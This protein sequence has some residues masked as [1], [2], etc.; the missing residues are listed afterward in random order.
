MH[1][2]VGSSGFGETEAQ[3]NVG[4][5]S[6]TKLIRDH[7]LLHDPIMEVHF[8]HMDNALDKLA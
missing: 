2:S 6:L 3:A 1:R 7:N 5:Y 8:R 4:S